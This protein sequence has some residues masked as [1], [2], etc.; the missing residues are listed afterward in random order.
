MAKVESFRGL[1]RWLVE[2]KFLVDRQ[3]G[4]AAKLGVTAVAVS[5]FLQGNGCRGEALN[6]QHL[7]KVMR[8]FRR[9]LEKT[10]LPHE[11]LPVNLPR[12]EDQHS[13][14][15]CTSATATTRPPPN[16]S[17]A[18]RPSVAIIT[19]DLSEASGSEGGFVL[20]TAL[21]SSVEDNRW[22][23]DVGEKTLFLRSGFR[24]LRTVGMQARSVMRGR[25]FE[26]FVEP[27][28]CPSELAVHG[29]P[30]WVAREW[31]GSS[32][33]ICNRRIIGR[34]RGGD[35]RYI[36]R[37]S[38]RKLWNAIA[39]YCEVGTQMNGLVHCG[40]THPVVQG[41][42]EAVHNIQPSTAPTAVPF[43][44]RKGLAGLNPNGSWLRHI[45]AIAGPR[46]VDA[47]R[48]ICPLNPATAFEQLLKRK[49]FREKWL[50]EVMR[51][52]ISKKAVE[53]AMLETPLV[54]GLVDTYHKLQGFK[55]KRQ[56]LSLIAPHLPYDTV[57]KLFGVSRCAR[58]H[59]NRTCTD[60]P[61]THGP[62]IPP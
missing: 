10:S 46:F 6:V 9:R 44:E 40:L 45:G 52:G 47:M 50:P 32:N 31:T 12:K 19:A 15:C 23:L 1:L 56:H 13:T 36:G 28:D 5:R 4:L 61:L 49:E 53:K 8:D 37:S 39:D 33:D 51:E 57:R 24:G 29:G 22:Q 27:L 14:R 16:A 17:T 55:L 7:D 34:E 30:L 42:L 62:C 54:K 59:T 18:S 21:G 60:R 58:L 26:F 20:I 11:I 41:A 43:G 38:P 25:T 3:S 48:D 2:T 35:G